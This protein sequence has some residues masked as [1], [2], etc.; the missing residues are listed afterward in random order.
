MPA[1]ITHEFFGRSV[2]E[3]L[4][5]TI[6]TSVDEKQAFLLGNQGPDPL[7]YAVAAPLIA[8]FSAFGSTMH[9]LHTNEELVAFREALDALPEEEQSVGRAYL[10]GFLCHYLLDSTMHPL[11]Y[12]QQYALCDAGVD[13]LSRKD[14][15]EVHAIIES[16]LD[17]VVLFT[18]TGHTIETFNT[19]TEI[20]QASDDV[21]RV[22]G[23]LYTPMAAAAFEQPMN[24]RVFGT[25]VKGF[26]LV[27][28][29]FYSPSGKKRE[30]L[31]RLE[32]LVR[33][34]SFYRS[35]SHR[36]VEATEC[37]FDNHEHAPW[38][39]P[40]T[41]ERSEASFWDLFESAQARA[42]NVFETFLQEGFTL[43]AAQAI[44]AGKNFSGNPQGS[45]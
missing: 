11:V 30:A 14:G 13:G 19:S 5:S 42:E 3:R 37:A 17:E 21:L 43:E 28:S 9:H 40:F 34:Y 38:K 33:P 20:L 1:I 23:S 8:G 32:E 25:C 39:N 7:F 31:G 36:V 45:K 6:G 18:R 2:Y 29:L 41:G 16:E 12:S 24:P 27:Q 15:N 4:E 26:R 22:V 35:M 10:L 44:T